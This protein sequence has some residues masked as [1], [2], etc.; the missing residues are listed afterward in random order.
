MMWR[1]LVFLALSCPMLGLLFDA[2]VDHS[3]T[4]IWHNTLD[5][6]ASS[7]INGGQVY[8]STPTFPTGQVARPL[9]TAGKLQ[10]TGDSRLFWG[11]TEVQ[12]I[13]A[14]WDDANGITVDLYFSGFGPGVDR[15]S[16]LW[17]VGHRRSDNFF[18]I[19]VRDDTLRINVRNDGGGPDRNTTHTIQTSSL[20][21]IAG[22]TYRLTVRQHVTLGNGG[23][24]EVYLDDLG[25]DVYSNETP[26]VVL[27]LPTGYYF[28]FPLEAGSGPALGMSI[29]NR[30]PFATASTILRGGEAIDEV[31]IFNGS[32]TPAQLDAAGLHHALG[33]ING[34][35]LVDFWDVDIM[36]G[37]W[38]VDNLDMSR[39]NLDEKGRINLADFAIMANEWLAGAS[40]SIAQQPTDLQLYEGSH[41]SF[42]VMATGLKP[43]TYRWQKE[44]VDLSDGGDVSGTTTDTLRIA[45]VDAS[46]S[47]KYRCVVTNNHGIAFSEE[48]TLT[49]VMYG[50]IGVSPS[51]H[52]ITYRGEVLMLVG[53]SGTQCA[54]Q[55]SNLD[56][57]QWIDDCASRGIRAIHVWSF[58]P[59]RQK[60][61][62]SQIEDR[63]GYV[64]P[65]VMP[66]AREDSGPLAYDQRYQWKLQ[67]F[68]EGPDGDMAH[69]WPRMRDMCSYARSKN[70][71]VGITMFTGWSKHDYSWIFHPLNV[72]NGGHLTN[73]EDAVIIASPGTEIWQESW[74][75]SWPNAKKTQWVWEQLSLKFINELGPMGNVFFVFFD[76]HSYAEGNMGDHFLSFF[77]SRGQIWVDWSNR[78][79]NVAWVMSGT[80]HNT[81][82]NADA[83]SGFNSGPAKPYLNLEG[84]PYMDDEVRTAFWSFSI[85]GGH[86]F[87]H[88]DADQETVRTGIMGYDPHVPSGD[89]GMYKR[90]WL[91][92]A[93]RLFN[94]HVE[95][96]NTLAPHNEL[97]G[98]GTY[99]LADPGR[100]YVIYSKIGSPGTF[101]LNL[102][103]STGK[104]LSCRF[105][106]PRDGQ[107]ESTF[108]RTGGDRSASF[109]KPDTN[110]W[111]LHIL[112][113]KP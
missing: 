102:I 1:T 32:F 35:R 75:D 37:N 62:G 40:V 13:F 104:P 109:V 10:S 25:A 110:D 26:L 43:L 56:H 63:W 80:L 76:E 71:L 70:V 4:P 21:L 50:D 5:D 47:G 98:S 15:D 44:G 22:E 84:E 24:M 14:G 6:L 77:K 93:S 54:T 23:D 48:V 67:L 52:Y 82:K 64:I 19:A 83:V 51:G 7:T 17:S 12:S 106:N 61:D 78:I 101:Y 34:D 41:A 113:D 16:G 29:G 45:N 59:V 38:L 9:T 86:Y 108:H 42:S 31:R 96:L 65:D 60:Q 87:F 33:D 49:V 72:N 11:T 53:D 88:A 57:R 3:P 8:G 2:G 69:Y 66:W 55:N 100:E 58:V 94:E 68:D 97:T 30:H 112:E 20:G 85:G 95:D 92:H 36:T 89:K 91:G 111:V 46:D 74:S 81:D 103:A 39:G 90:D 73:R 99:C 79:S 18:I 28:D 105:Y 27:D 107:F